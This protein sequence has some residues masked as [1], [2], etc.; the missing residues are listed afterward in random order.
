M[1]AHRRARILLYATF[2]GILFLGLVLVARREGHTTIGVKDAQ[3]AGQVGCAQVTAADLHRTSSH[4]VTLRAIVYGLLADSQG[5]YEHQRFLLRCPSGLTVL[6]V[7]DV[8]IG[9]RVP[10]RLGDVVTVRGIYVWNGLGG[11]VH[12]THHSLGAPQGGWIL[13]HS[14]VYAWISF[15]TKTWTGPEL[16]GPAVDRGRVALDF[17]PLYP[18]RA[19]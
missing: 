14:H 12:F 8:S 15:R 3:R 6:V 9:Q 11:L 2:C 10:V 17:A 5:R 4:W 1:S 16:G 19:T 18:A 13:D 7:N